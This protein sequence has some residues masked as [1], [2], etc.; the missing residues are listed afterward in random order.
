M[1]Q[2]LRAG[3]IWRF[4]GDAGDDQLHDGLYDVPSSRGTWC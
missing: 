1:T 2:R 4:Y 3:I